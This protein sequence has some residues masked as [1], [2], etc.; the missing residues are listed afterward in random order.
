MNPMIGTMAVAVVT[1]VVVEEEVEVEKIAETGEVV[2]EVEER[3]TARTG[4]SLCP[5]MRE[6]RRNSSIRVMG[7]LAS[8]LIG[9]LLVYSLCPKKCPTSLCFVLLESVRMGT[10]FGHSIENTNRIVSSFMLHPEPAPL[11]CPLCLCYSTSRK[12]TLT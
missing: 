2:V 8:T 5:G 1:M 7:P 12:F 4:P 10:F 11:S 3:D 9:W 6:W